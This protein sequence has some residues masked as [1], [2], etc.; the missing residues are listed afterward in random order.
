MAKNIDISKKVKPLADRILIKEIKP[1]SEKKTA[2]GIIIPGTVNEDKESKKGEI[3]AIGNGRYED[4]KLIPISVKI[5]EQVI[6]QWGDKII[7]EGEEFYLVKES[8]LL[9]IIK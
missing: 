9:A 6:F 2:S 4:G 7:V 8:E 3:I 1:N 5:G